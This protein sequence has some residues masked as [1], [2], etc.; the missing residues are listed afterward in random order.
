MIPDAGTVCFGTYTLTGPCG[1]LDA[2]KGVLI[3]TDNRLRRLPAPVPGDATTISGEG[4][5]LTCA[6]GWVIGEGARPGDY[7]LVRQQ[8]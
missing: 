6:A 1:R 8:P 7:E 5:T 2:D 4:W 3:T